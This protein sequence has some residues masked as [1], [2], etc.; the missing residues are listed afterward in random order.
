MSYTYTYPH[1]AIAAD[2]VVFG[3]DS[4]KLQVLLI[5][6]K[7]EPCKGMWAFPGGFMKIDET[8]ENA[9]RRELQEET[10]LIISRL[11]PFGTFSTVNR[12]HRE[13]VVSIAYYA[14]TTPSEV[15]GR[16]D[17]KK[18]GWFSLDK[19]PKLAFDHD[20]MLVKALNQFRKDLSV[21]E[22]DEN[23][24]LEALENLQ[25]ICEKVLFSPMLRTSP[26]QILSLK[27]HEIF[28]FGSNLQGMH[29]GGAAYIAHQKFGAIY[30]QGVGLQ[31]ESYAIPTM[32]G[33]T[34][35]IVPY[36]NEFI[37]FAKK[38]SE[39]TF[40]VTRIGCGIAGFRDNEIA[41]L[42]NQAVTVP[43]IR[44]PKSFWEELQ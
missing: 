36:V 14:L 3:Y 10:G 33:G 11:R 23:I 9:A 15:I 1:P 13:R 30:G 37:D 18:A 12:D 28:V 43:N 16:D 29:D 2:C 26:N 39:L 41:P 7:F 19:L 24:S 27:P 40:L 17:A 35:T 44:L 22:A 38:H 31:G 20:E 25:N 6:R 21:G 32:H 42:F 8:A 4:E 34:E 5:E